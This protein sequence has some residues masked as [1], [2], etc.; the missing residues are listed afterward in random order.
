[1][2]HE[3]YWRKIPLLEKPKKLIMPKSDKIVGF[4]NSADKIVAK[5][6]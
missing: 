3:T 6:V 2:N 5:K 4:V 1:M